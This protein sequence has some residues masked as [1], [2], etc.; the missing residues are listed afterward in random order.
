[1]RL[2]AGLVDLV[3]CLRLGSNDDLSGTPARQSRLVQTFRTPQPDTVL[4]PADDMDK[5]VEEKSL[6]ER[7]AA[8][9]MIRTPVSRPSYPRFRSCNNFT[10]GS[11]AVL[12][13]ADRGEVGVK[14]VFA[15]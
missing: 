8:E 15:E 6:S 11:P 3:G 10:E 5:L 1:M 4:D 14:F 12:R 13:S 7:L 9:E 2:L